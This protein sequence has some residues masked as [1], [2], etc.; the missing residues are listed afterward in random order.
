M[1]NPTPMDTIIFPAFCFFVNHIRNKPNSSISRQSGTGKK[2]G[3]TIF[4]NKNIVNHRLRGSGFNVQ[5]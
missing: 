1:I 5:G 4:L 3:A 2:S